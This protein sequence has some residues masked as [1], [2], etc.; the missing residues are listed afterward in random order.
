MH[1]ALA[2]AGR[3][4]SDDLCVALQARNIRAPAVA[5]AR[6]QAA[7]QLVNHRRNAALMGDAPLDTF[8][9]ELLAR[10]RA[11]EIERVLEIAIAAPATHCAD[12]SHPAIF[13]EA[14]S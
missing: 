9:H 12:R 4:D 8:G 2:E 10:V 11:F 3:R 1:V 14:A 5:H 7:D 6:A 13:L